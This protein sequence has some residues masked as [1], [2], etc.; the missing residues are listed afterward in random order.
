MLPHTKA[1]LLLVLLLGPVASTS[2]ELYSGECR[3]ALV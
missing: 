3:L 2:A 1:I